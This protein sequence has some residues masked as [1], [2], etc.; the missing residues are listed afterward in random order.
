MGRTPP[1]SLDYHICR[2]P[3]QQPSS[4]H[5]RVGGRSRAGKDGQERI[6]GAQPGSRQRMFGERVFGGEVLD[7]LDD[8][9]TLPG[10]ELQEGAQQAETFDGTGRRRSELEMQ[11][12]REIEVFHLAP[13][14]G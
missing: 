13:M 9:K 2:T 14:Q 10:C 6:S 7:K 8:L 1:F 3:C 11:L 12:S 4:R 5:G